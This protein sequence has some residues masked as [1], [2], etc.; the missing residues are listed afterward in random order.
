[1]KTYNIYYKGTYIGFV[2]AESQEEAFDKA[3]M[4]IIFSNGQC[5]RKDVRVEKSFF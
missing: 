5:D 1:M 4:Q 3:T 2:K